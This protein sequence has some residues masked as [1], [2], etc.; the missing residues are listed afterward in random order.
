MNQT[1][2][3]LRS[4]GEEEALTASIHWKT[5]DRICREQEETVGEL[6]DF[7]DWYEVRKINIKQ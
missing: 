5:L 6:P 1:A 2:E 3:W 7:I 4:I